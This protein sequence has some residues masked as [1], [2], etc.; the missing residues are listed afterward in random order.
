[1]HLL[2]DGPVAGQVSRTI[3]IPAGSGVSTDKGEWS[4]S[5]LLSLF[6][7]LG[8]ALPMILGALEMAEAAL[9]L[10]D[11]EKPRAAKIKAPLRLAERAY[12]NSDPASMRKRATLA[13]GLSRL[14]AK[15][16]P[17]SRLAA[18]YAMMSERDQASDVRLADI[19]GSKLSYQLLRSYGATT[20]DD[21][22]APQPML[23]WKKAW[24]VPDVVWSGD[25]TLMRNVGKGAAG[26]QAAIAEGPAFRTRQAALNNAGVST[27][28]PTGA[29]SA[30]P[31][32]LAAQRAAGQVPSSFVP[33]RP[34][35][36]TPSVPT[37]QPN[38]T[39]T[40]PY[41]QSAIGDPGWDPSWNVPASG[42]GIVMGPNTDPLAGYLPPNSQPA[43]PSRPAAQPSGQPAPPLAVWNPPVAQT[44]WMGDPVPQQSGSS[45]GS[46]APGWSDPGYGFGWMEGEDFGSEESYGFS[47]FPISEGEA[48]QEQLGADNLGAWFDHK[49]DQAAT[50]IRMDSRIGHALDLSAWRTRDDD[51]VV[52]AFDAEDEAASRM[53]Y[54]SSCGP[55]GMR[56]NDF[57]G[58][59]KPGVF[60]SSPSVVASITPDNPGWFGEVNLATY[61]YTLRLGN[62]SGEGRSTVSLAHELAHIANRMYK[63]DLSHEQVHE[64]GVFFGQTGFPAYASFLKHIRGA[65]P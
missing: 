35:S 3:G 16:T 38:P 30:R 10:L 46:A 21:R 58:N 51:P 65:Q 53:G 19:V 7:A 40:T 62:G 47:S 43:Q 24:W 44:N 48:Y 14:K 63:L 15:T 20:S 23:M 12:P 25:N 1:M 52:R 39:Q 13:T 34:T 18:G 42:G 17:A 61:P 49:I 31:E 45:G 64:V 28:V 8:K 6:V 22:I 5:D 41:G 33:G 59:L 55:G 50:L 56:Q 37:T 9:I 4:A 2:S 29:P 54:C 32:L 36:Y 57:S 27:P 60:F 11:G 26:K